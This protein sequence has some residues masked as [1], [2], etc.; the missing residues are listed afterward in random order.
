MQTKRFGRLRAG[1]LGRFGFL[2]S[3]EET[4]RFVESS[5]PPRSRV[6]ASPN[7]RRRLRAFPPGLLELLLA[8]PGRAKQ[9]R[10]A[11]AWPSPCARR[12]RVPPSRRREVAVGGGGGGL[13][14]PSRARARRACV[15]RGGD[16]RALRY[17]SARSRRS[18]T[19][20]ERLAAASA[21]SS[22]ARRSAGA[23]RSSAK[24][25]LP[26]QDGE[27]RRLGAS[28]T[29]TR[30]A[31]R[32]AVSAA[33]HSASFSSRT[34]PPPEERSGSLGEAAR[35]AAAPASPETRGN[36]SASAVGASSDSA[37]NASRAQRRGRA[38]GAPSRRQG[39]SPPRALT[40]GARR[41]KDRNSRKGSKTFR[42]PRRRSFSSS[43]PSSRLRGSKTFRIF[44]TLHK[45]G[46]H[47][48]G[49]ARAWDPSP[50]RSARTPR[51]SRR[52]GAVTDLAP[53]QSL[54]GAHASPTPRT[55][56]ASPR[57]R[58]PRAEPPPRAWGGKRR[59]G[60]PRRTPR[61]RQRF[62]SCFFFCRF[63]LRRFLYAGS[64]PCQT[65]ASTSS[66]KAP[67]SASSSRARARSLGSRAPAA[68]RHVA[69][70][71]R[72]VVIA[73][74]V[75]I[76]RDSPL[77][78]Y[79]RSDRKKRAATASLALASAATSIESFAEELRGSSAGICT[80]A[81]SASGSGG[82]PGGEPAGFAAVTSAAAATSAT[83]PETSSP[84]A[85]AL[86]LLVSG[87]ALFSPSH[88]K[89]TPSPRYGILKLV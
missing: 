86:F 21:L 69:E 10:A 37:A 67:A 57:A 13:P 47:S 56:R 25:G 54:R 11:P 1:R 6:L 55:R 84:E 43:P 59:A 17:S 62:S 5:S 40:W 12:A 8:E 32:R 58:R 75:T 18:R 68:Q 49:H 73:R 85:P 36:S 51:R 29:A 33:T 76:A 31:S 53:P 63:F 61:R 23:L 52:R 88:V 81:H 26:A 3:A 64:P 65:N 14:A 87:G 2:A 15:A 34:A 35:P 79:E 48:R 80:S 83:S 30:A 7:K 60:A 70:I 27:P 74:D 22:A 77:L 9:S 50:P 38:R 42:R 28:F 46:R 4:P 45:D 71:E 72:F 39:A 78:R 89:T 19:R 82:E 24:R 41:R 16:R 66:A 44:P 20:L